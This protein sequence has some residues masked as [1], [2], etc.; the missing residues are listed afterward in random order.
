MSN[1]EL[2]V[3]TNRQELVHPVRNWITYNLKKKSISFRK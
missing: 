2:N 3:K 1:S